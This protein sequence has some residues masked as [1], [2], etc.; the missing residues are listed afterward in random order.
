MANPMYGQNKDDARL[1]KYADGLAKVKVITKS[2]VL[3]A[4][5]SGSYIVFDMVSANATI[6]LPSP[7]DGMWFEFSFAGTAAEAQDYIIDTGSDTNYF[8]GGLSILDTDA[9]TDGAEALVAILPDGNSNSKM[10]LKTVDNGTH[11][12]LVSDGT[13]WY[14]SGQICSATATAVVYADQ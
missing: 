11:F 1:N 8:R 3:H 4:S 6:K 7:S 5:D 14:T 2:E 9:T 13:L 12:R 10:T